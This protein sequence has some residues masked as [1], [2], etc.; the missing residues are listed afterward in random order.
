[1]VRIIS[2]AQEDPNV[3]LMQG[4]QI[5]RSFRD[6]QR[7]NAEEKRRNAQFMMAMQEQQLAFKQAQA[8]QQQM[9]NQQAQMGDAQAL[10]E[11]ALRAKK[12]PK[13]VRSED[14]L[15][16]LSGITDPKARAL[17]VASI[18]DL[19]QQEDRAEMQQAAAGE[20]ER[21]AKDGL[22]DEA[23]MQTYQQRLQAGEEPENIVEEFG[24]ARMQRA[25]TQANIDENTEF[26]AQIDAA[27]QA[28]PPG[29][30][31]KLA[32]IAANEY[33]AS[34]SLLEKEGS[35][36]KVLATI[37][38]AGV[39]SVS[40]FQAAEQAKKDRME[41]ALSPNAQAPGLGGMTAQQRNKELERMPGGRGHGDYSS[42]Y[43]RDPKIPDLSPEF[44]AQGKARKEARYPG[45]TKPKTAGTAPKGEAP[46][47]DAVIQEALQAGAASGQD[48][49][50]KLKEAGIPPTQ[51]NAIAVKRALQGW[52]TNAQNR[53][54]GADRAPVQ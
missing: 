54:G 50:A 18:Q 19:F 3:A 46:N 27:I 16:M 45:S 21:A 48:I 7:A 51:E 13:Q 10:Q 29:R 35:G 17:A 53:T 8:E 44:K 24:K 34:P 25:T 32:M 9:L 39:G 52:K 22:I 42:F 40:E 28:M 14:A 47:V 26:I 11:V 43:S 4:M 12:D 23:G 15:R 37:Q 5:G 33:K 41:E 2:G 49:V 6:S 31:K 20:I 30:G 1:M 38:K 36:A